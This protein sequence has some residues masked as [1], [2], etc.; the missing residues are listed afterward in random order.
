MNV[1]CHGVTDDLSGLLD[2]VGFEFAPRH[3]V[4]NYRGEETG[5]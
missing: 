4:F 5:R 1:G 3:A 2:I